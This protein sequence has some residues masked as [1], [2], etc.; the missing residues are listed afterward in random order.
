MSLKV[1][2]AILQH[3][4]QRLAKCTRHYPTSSLFISEIFMSQNRQKNY[5]GHL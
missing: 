5:H 4:V 1:S 3:P 2:C